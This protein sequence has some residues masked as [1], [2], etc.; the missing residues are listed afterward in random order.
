M[1][2]VDRSQ[3]CAG[4][5]HPATV[6]HH[7]LKVED[8]IVSGHPQ[9]GVFQVFLVWI[10]RLKVALELCSKGREGKRVNST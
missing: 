9:E 6:C 5:V 7:Q 10:G 3:G 2:T 8:G 4:Q 1:G